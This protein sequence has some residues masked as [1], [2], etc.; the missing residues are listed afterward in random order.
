MNRFRSV[1]LRWITIFAGLTLC[2]GS[3]KHLSAAATTWP[4]LLNYQGQLTD[5]SGVSAV[6][7]ASY[8]L[9]F[10]VYPDSSTVTPLWSET[11]TVTTRKGLFHVVLGTVTSMASL[12]AA[13]YG[14][15]LWLGLKVGADA[16]MTPRQQLLP[17]AYAKNAQML[18]GLLPNNAPNNLVVLDSSGRVPAGLVQGASLAAPL[19]LTASAASYSLNVSNSSA[20][21]GALALYASA[22]N[23]V[24]AQALN[25]SGYGIWGQTAAA[26]NASAVGVR[27]SANAGIGVLAQSVSGVGLSVTSQSNSQAAL[28]AAGAFPARFTVNTAVA[29]NAAVQASTLAGDL[30][31]DLA[32][33]GNAAGVYAKVTAGSSFGVSATSNA[34]TGIFGQTNSGTITDY[35]VWGANSSAGAN[36]AGVF[37]S[38]GTGVLG[39]GSSTGVSGSSATGTGVIGNGGIGVLGQTNKNAGFGVEGIVDAAFSGSTAVLGINNYVSGT[40]INGRH[41]GTGAGIGVRGGSVSGVSAYGVYGN[42]SGTSA[43]GVAGFASANDGVG[44]MGW[45]GNGSPVTYTAAVMGRANSLFTGIGVRGEGAKGV[46]GVSGSTCGVCAYNLST[47]EA[48]PIAGLYANSAYNAILAEST[49]T[50]DVGYGVY[51]TTQS[52]FDTSA[53]GYFASQGATG[54]TYG[55]YASNASADGHAVHAA[56]AVGGYNFYSDTA[57][58]SPLYGFYHY[59]VNTTGSNLVGVFAQESCATCYAGDFVNTVA[60]SGVGAALNVEGRMRVK[61]SA[62]VFTVTSSNYASY[63]LSNPYIISNCLIFL[64][65]KTPVASVASV[66]FSSPGQATVTFT[67]PLTG[68]ATYQYLILGQ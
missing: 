35:G 5:A 17:A 49:N 51:G 23:A 63:T 36:S 50:T 9:L 52:V 31:A 2:F 68:D 43:I 34:S 53:A 21:A 60:Q 64:T 54:V 20:V 65:V 61:N 39:S 59:D 8:S 62:G 11:Q 58:Q 57:S 44:V 13:S 24:L 6:A 38:G 30:V 55:I 47:T 67:P 32:D 56:A 41:V 15:D 26:D 46:Y 29:N 7:D 14:T 22:S 42:V 48:Y 1:S 45:Q 40:A 10:S 4:N 19:D 12:P 16:E 37:G 18:G 3:Q 25:A 33:R 66:A 27:G 28:F